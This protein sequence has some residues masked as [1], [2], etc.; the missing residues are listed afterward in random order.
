[1]RELTEEFETAIE[2]DCK[3]SELDEI[4]A[5]RCSSDNFDGAQYNFFGRYV[6]VRPIIDVVAETDGMAIESLA[7]THDG[8]HICLSVF[9]ADIPEQPHPAFV[10]S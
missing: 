1:M 7:H 8:D 6:P 10:D 3:A 5:R 9:V 2:N 4:T